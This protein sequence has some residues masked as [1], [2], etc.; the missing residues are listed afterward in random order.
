MSDLLH[1]LLS[2]MA[3]RPRP[4]DRISAGAGGAQRVGVGLGRRGHRW[5]PQSVL[6]TFLS[7][8]SPLYCFSLGLLLPGKASPSGLSNTVLATAIVAIMGMS[9]RRL[10]KARPGTGR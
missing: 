9:L 2:S 5:R 7:L 3:V 1:Q 8:S 10:R 6:R 4:G